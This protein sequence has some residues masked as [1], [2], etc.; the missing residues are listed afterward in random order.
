MQ[1]NQTWK[2]G[3]FVIH[4][5]RQEWGR[6]VVQPNSISPKFKIIFETAGL[7]TIDTSL[8]ALRA[9]DANLDQVA[10]T[11]EQRKTRLK[12]ARTPKYPQYFNR[13]WEFEYITAWKK[14]WKEGGMPRDWA[15]Q[16]PQLFLD[17]DLQSAL[18][19]DG[20]GKP[21]VFYAWLGSILVW[22]QF[23][24]PS[25]MAWARP[26]LRKRRDQIM[27]TAQNQKFETLLNEHEWS[28]FPQNMVFRQDFSKFSLVLV[29]EDEKPIADK[30]LQAVRK[31]RQ[32]LGVEV[33]L[34]RV[35]SEKF[36]HIMA[37]H[38]PV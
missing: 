34:V 31:V 15:D 30:R 19:Q 3:D 21:G 4:P 7:K 28:A 23:H 20:S 16:Y 2:A 35:R 29:V 10:K 27:G 6:G 33:D 8:V 5:R 32:I 36:Q 1:N 18:E 9:W 11:G 38:T 14:F 37:G 26:H 17:Q 13:E 22:E 12:P 24:F 25:Q